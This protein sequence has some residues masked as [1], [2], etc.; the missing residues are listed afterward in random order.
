MGNMTIRKQGK[1]KDVYDLGDGRYL[2]KFKDEVTVGEDGAFDPGGNATGLSIA[3]MGRASLRMS[4]YYFARFA[5][6]GIPT[7]FVDADIGQGT[8]TVRPA[9]HFGQG[10]EFICRLKAAGSF[11]RRY[12]GV[13]EEG[14]DLDFLVEVTL[15]DDARGDPFLNEETL[16]K[17]GFIA[18]AEEY[19][20]LC[21][22]TRRLAKIVRDDL[23][24][25]GLTLIDLKFEFG[26]VDGGIALI[27]EV[28]AG[29]MRV[30]KDGR[31]MEPLELE[32][33]YV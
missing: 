8:M 7:H 5:A 17:L 14:R 23:A 19:G 18:S 30:M 9:R 12:G 3:G 29:N 4:A 28:S 10:L 11:L 15:K 22:L 24:A 25:K 31:T 26:L 13:C 27:D 6:A 32:R 21:G 1:T 2:L 33:Y 20:T 16:I